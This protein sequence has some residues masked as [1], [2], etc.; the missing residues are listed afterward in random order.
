MVQFMLLDYTVR[1][2]LYTRSCMRA[3]VRSSVSS[4]RA[5]DATLTRISR[6]ARPMRQQI[7]RRCSVTDRVLSRHPTDHCGQMITGRRVMLVI[8]RTI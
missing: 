7:P 4:C 2:D 5:N 8:M 1:R 3:V 6:A